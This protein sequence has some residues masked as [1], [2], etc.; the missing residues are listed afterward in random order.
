MRIG[1]IEITPLSAMLV[2]IPICVV[3]ELMHAD[4]AW[5]FITAG[6]AIIPLAGLMGTATEH[7]A[8]VLAQLPCEVSYLPSPT[9]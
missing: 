5:I 6:L 8:E 3:L 1:S 9:A 2:F 7:L 4:P